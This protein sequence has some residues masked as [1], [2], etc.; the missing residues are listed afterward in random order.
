MFPFLFPL[1]AVSRHGFAKLGF[2]AVVD[3]IF[4]R[5]LREQKPYMAAGT[6]SKDPPPSLL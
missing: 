1:K 6:A 3:F 2:L 4:S 5:D